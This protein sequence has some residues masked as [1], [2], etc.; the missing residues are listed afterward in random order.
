VTAKLAV[1]SWVKKERLV[2]RSDV[3]AGFDCSSSEISAVDLLI[4]AIVAPY[5]KSELKTNF[6][7]RN[8]AFGLGQGA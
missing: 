1:P 5:K 7:I 3:S 4:S 2:N 8:D 6:H